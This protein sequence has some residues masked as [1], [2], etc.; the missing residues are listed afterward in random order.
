M[1]NHP[2]ATLPLRH[3]ATLLLCYFIASATVVLAVM[4]VPVTLA[5]SKAL[6]L[7]ETCI[8]CAFT[9]LLNTNFQPNRACYLLIYFF[10]SF[11]PPSHFFDLAL[12]KI[13]PTISE[14]SPEMFK[15]LFSM[16]YKLRTTISKWRISLVLANFSY[17]ANY[18][19]A[20]LKSSSPVAE[21]RSSAE[22][23]WQSGRVAKW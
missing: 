8:R 6:K 23:G 5:P 18:L 14:K 20:K 12:S 1:L 17:L 13:R 22:K 4:L 7:R 16:F 15:S 21:G 10:S 19:S 2:L 3:S 11:P 9:S